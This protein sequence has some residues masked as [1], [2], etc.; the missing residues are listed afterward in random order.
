MGKKIPTSL[1]GMEPT[2][3]SSGVPGPK[4]RNELH[5]FTYRHQG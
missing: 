2:S 4:V 1:W 3:L 5:F